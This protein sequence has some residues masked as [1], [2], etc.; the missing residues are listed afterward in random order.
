MASA[1]TVIHRVSFWSCEEGDGGFIFPFRRST[2]VGELKPRNSL[3]HRMLWS[4][5]EL[6]L[7]YIEGAVAVAGRVAAGTY[8]GDAVDWKQLGEFGV[9][10]LHEGTRETRWVFVIFYV[11]FSKNRSFSKNLTIFKKKKILNKKL[12]KLSINLRKS[13]LKYLMILFSI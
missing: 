4:S 8:R 5:Q 12:I 1:S 7:A 11:F 10:E 6:G 13:F 3:L 2:R 9:G